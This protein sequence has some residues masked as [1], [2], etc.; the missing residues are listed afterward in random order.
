MD[1]TR[2]A[3]PIET[4]WD[5]LFALFDDMKKFAAEHPN[6]GYM[7]IPSD[8][9]GIHYNPPRVARLGWSAFIDGGDEEKAKHWTITL[10]NTRK[11]LA[12][13]RPNLPSHV[14]GI[15]AALKSQAGRH[16]LLTSVIGRDPL[17]PPQHE[18]HER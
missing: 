15:E 10:G 16:E 13:A 6:E 5:D 9:P 1:F 12:K 8:D 17:L 18:L 4:D 11:S 7:F 14:A 3:S 2:D